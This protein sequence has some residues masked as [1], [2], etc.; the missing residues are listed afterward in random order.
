VVEGAIQI[1]PRGIDAT[2]HIVVIGAGFTGLADLRGAI[3]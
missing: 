1:K 2:P 3:G